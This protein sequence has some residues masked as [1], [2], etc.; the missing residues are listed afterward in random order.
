MSDPSPISGHSVKLDLHA[1]H[2]PHI[3]D[4]QESPFWRLKCSCG[5]RSGAGTNLDAVVELYGIHVWR[6]AC[7][8]M[9]D[10]SAGYCSHGS[11]S[12]LCPD[13]SSFGQ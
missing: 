13:C 3:R 2:I 11:L 7:G 1:Q 8:L 4:D 6:T 10:K 9:M 12:G 5:W